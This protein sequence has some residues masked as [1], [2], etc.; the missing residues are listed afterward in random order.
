MKVPT[1]LVVENE[2]VVRNLVQTILR[3]SG[4]EVAAFATGEEALER[5]EV[6]DGFIPLLITDVDLGPSLDGIELVN[7][8]RALYP[9]M[10]ILYISGQDNETVSR[11]VAT[12]QAY[13]LPKPFTP[14]GLTEKVTA[15]LSRHFALV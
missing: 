4:F 3:I 9:P 2:D 13:F 10:Q 12:G 11:E 14:R 8:L 5:L 15:I 6:Q 1:V 7:A